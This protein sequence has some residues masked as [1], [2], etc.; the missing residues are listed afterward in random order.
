[1]QVP[2]QQA[3]VSTETFFVMTCDDSP[4]YN[5]AEYCNPA[6]LPIVVGYDPEPADLAQVP[7]N[8]VVLETAKNV[9]TVSD[10]DVQ[11][12]LWHDPNT[13]AGNVDD[14]LMAESNTFRWYYDSSQ[15]GH[16]TYFVSAL[17]NATTTGILREHAMRL[18]STITCTDIAPEDFPATCGGTRPF[19]TS[20]SRHQELTIDIC[21]P[22]DYS[23]TPWTL[24]RNR[25]DLEEDLY[26]K[27]HV[28]YN[29][30]LSY[31]Y[32][33]SIQNFSSHCKSTATRGY[34]EMGNYHNNDTAGP[35]IETWPDN[36]TMLENF[37]DYLNFAGNYGIPTV[38]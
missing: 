15:Q 36:I 13:S 29:S 18:N 30:T 16:P 31:D 24:S 6:R 22:G 34:F 32:S 19:T 3:L 2:I 38:V 5:F 1:M 23:K 4:L 8:P 9:V 28:P 14:D 37:N 25:Q 17:P 11:L 7:Q 21:V 35:L 20:Y 12:R 26:I 33:T 10:L 27:V